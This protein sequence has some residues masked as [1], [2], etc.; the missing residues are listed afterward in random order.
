MI[1]TEENN[2]ESYDQKTAMIG[3][4]AALASMVAAVIVA[5]PLLGKLDQ[6]FQYIQEFAGFFTRGIVVIFLLG[7][8]WKKATSTSALVAAIFP[9]DLSLTLK[10]VWPEL[11]FMDR[12][13]LVFLLCVAIAVV[14]TFLAD[15][16][17]QINAVDLQS[18]EFKTTGGFNIA[19]LGI[20]LIFIALYPLGGKPFV[21]APLC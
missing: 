18:I 9:A 20:I 21:C 14:I 5:K 8:F 17:D 7:F 12:V 2:S 19:T 13:G 15:D 10:L 11:P 6:A 4:T 1:T 3:R 16:K